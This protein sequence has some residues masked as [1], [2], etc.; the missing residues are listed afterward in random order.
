MRFNECLGEFTDCLGEF[1]DCLGEFTDCLGEFRDCLEDRNETKGVR[2]NECLGE[3]RDCLEDRNESKGDCLIKDSWIDE[4]IDTIEMD[5]AS[6]KADS[7]TT[8]D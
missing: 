5:T 6:S 7:E 4:F 1:T 2:V 8:T 3:F